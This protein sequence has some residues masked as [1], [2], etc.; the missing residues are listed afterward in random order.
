M[1]ATWRRERINEARHGSRQV[2][3]AGLVKGAMRA[4]LGAGRSLS[5][6]I[7]AKV[8]ATSKLWL[9]ARECLTVSN[10]MTTQRQFGLCLQMV[11]ADMQQPLDSIDMSFFHTNVPAASLITIVPFC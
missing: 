3:A 4:K 6:Q 5:Y 8:M 10:N 1:D 11:C 9:D 2:T 7:L